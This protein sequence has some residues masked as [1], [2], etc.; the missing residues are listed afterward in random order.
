MK[1][2][3]VFLSLVMIV[4]GSFSLPRVAAQ[5]KKDRPYWGTL[6]GGVD[7][8]FGFYNKD[9]NRPDLDKFGTNSYVNLDYNYRHLTV[10]LQ[11]EV[12]EPP[13]RGFESELKGH[14]LT[15]YYLNCAL[16]KYD[17]TVGSFFEQFGSGLIFR[18]YEERML[19]FDNSLRGVSVKASPFRWMRV[20]A[21]SG[22]PRKFLHYSKSWVSGADGEF[23]ISDLW[24]KDR[25]RTVAVGGAWVLRSNSSKY[26]ESSIEPKH[27]NLFSGRASFTDNALNLSLEY[28]YKQKAMSYAMEVGDYVNQ[29]GDALLFN[30]NYNVRGFGLAGVFRRIEHMA[31]RVDA[32]PVVAPTVP[33][34]YIPALTKQH[35]YALP[36]LYP[37]IPNIEGEIGGQL[38][39]FVDI[40]MGRYPLKL[41]VNG[42]LYRSLGDNVKRTAPFFG[43]GSEF[44]Y[45]EAN[46]EME[47]R[48]LPTLKTTL[49]FYFQDR[50]DEVEGRVKSYT[51][52][53]DF[54]WRI[55]RKISLR[56]EVQNMN[57]QARDK[58]WIYGLSELGWAPHWMVYGSAMYNYRADADLKTHYYNV[59][60]SFTYN[61][62]NASLDYGKNRAG[63][64]CVGGI[65][66]FV[67]EYKG[68]TLRLSYVF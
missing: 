62:L 29:S 42:S 48:F 67:P 8:S 12:F 28:T 5:E 47:K 60:V 45:G 19:G 22:Q 40:A 27:I 32:E 6:R 38:D 31:F 21:F 50:N 41:S 9:H 13:M 46:I 4:V 10:G 15:Q 30:V 36:A 44:L 66:R 34:N 61:S 35:R 17:I 56:T 65:C 53:M 1:R 2:A 43:D 57:T 23:I 33:L 37:H 24:D 26:D 55:Q 25:S 18:S 63:H 54:L 11:Y 3:F 58:A 39:M 14:R 16:Q 51:E 7:G 20:K 64:Q 52:V 49:G 59:G 68:A